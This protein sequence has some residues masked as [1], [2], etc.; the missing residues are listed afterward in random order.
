MY[1]KY[2]N[3]YDQ[4]TYENTTKLVLRCSVYFR[5]RHYLVKIFEDINNRSRCLTELKNKVELIEYEID[6][7]ED[8]DV[9]EKLG[10]DVATLGKMIIQHVQCFRETTPIF[11]Q[12]FV[13]K[14][15][16]RKL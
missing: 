7:S 5:A 2:I 11:D 3:Q 8:F 4:I 10:H 1:H 6:E 15:N 13:Y 14:N 9:L 12:V 16:V